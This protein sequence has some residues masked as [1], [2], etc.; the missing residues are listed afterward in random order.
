[1]KSTYLDSLPQY[2][3]A[4]TGRIHTSFHQTGA[5]TGR[6][7]SSDPN[8]QNIPI[9]SVEGRAI[10]TAFV[11]EEGWRFL[12]ADYSQV[13][14]RLLA[15]L[16]GDEG[17]REAFR[18]GED[19]HRATAARI[20]KVPLEEVTSTLRSRAKAVN[21]G[22]IYGMGPQRLARETNVTMNEARQFIDDYFTTYPAVKDYQEKTIADAQETGYVMTLLGRRR[23]LPDIQSG[24]PRIFAQARNV[25]VNTPLQGTAAD[26]IKLA[27]IRV[28]ERLRTDGL[29]ARML[30]QIHDELLFEV[31]VDEIEA[32]TAMVREEMTTALP[33]EVPLIV[34]I[35]V[36]ANWSE[37]H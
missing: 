16:S 3:N 33:L 7:S 17:L 14:L 8:L 27:M 34:D 10:R 4:E 37:A 11:P 2:V 6:L 30:L 13:E 23:Y 9:R 31:P 19:I 22:V 28:D 21:F 32:L 24:D 12:S 5:A 15:H 25:A 29:A 36:G 1:L 35:G 20:F 26:M 18:H